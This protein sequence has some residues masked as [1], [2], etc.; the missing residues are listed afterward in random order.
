MELWMK[1][2]ISCMQ[3]FMGLGHE[4]HKHRPTFY[5]LV[6]HKLTIMRSLTDLR[7]FVMICGVLRRFA[8]FF[9]DLRSVVASLKSLAPDLRWIAVIC[10]VLWWFAVFRQTLAV[11]IFF[12][13]SGK[14][15]QMGPVNRLHMGLNIIV[16]WIYE[17]NWKVVIALC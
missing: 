17:T 16:Y 12:V 14:C 13:V 2:F 7:L 3:Y 1:H 6:R 15:K 9:T 11:L 4:Q 8:V 10:G 5:K